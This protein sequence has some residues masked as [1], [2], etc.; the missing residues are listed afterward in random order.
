MLKVENINTFIGTAQILRGISLNVEKSETV[1]LAGRNGAGKTTTVKSIIGLLPVKLGKIELNGRDITRIPSYERA[2]LGIGYSPDDAGIFMELTAAEN[3]KVTV[4]LSKSSKQNLAQRDT[5]MEKALELFPEL[6][7]LLNRRGL[8]LSG[9][10]KKMLAI[11]RAMELNPSVLLLDEPF[12]GL[13]PLV[14][15]R[16]V[17]AL[18]RI[19]EMG[20]SALIA[21]SNLRTATRVADRLYII[22]RGEIIYAGGPEEIFKHEDVMRIMQGQ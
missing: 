20:V 14:V 22:D 19:K 13:A 7:P 2:R 18:K 12:E 8:Y 4:L 10:E 1:L 6:R 16:L 9:G 17:E 3:L 15:Q 11:G 21:E 5:G